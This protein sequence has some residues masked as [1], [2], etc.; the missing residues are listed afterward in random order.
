[1]KKANAKLFQDNERVRA[2]NS[3]LLIS[4]TLL[5]RQ[6]QIELKGYIKDVE[7]KREQDFHEETLVLVLG[8]R[9]G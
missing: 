5:G 3:K 1:L 9:N 8:C 4:D 7:K 2:L 6:E